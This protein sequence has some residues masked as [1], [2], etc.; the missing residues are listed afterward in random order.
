RRH[1]G[2][3]GGGGRGGLGPP[4][5][6][7]RLHPEHAG[8]DALSGPALEL[9]AAGGSPDG[10]APDLRLRR[11]A[12]GAGAT[13]R[14]RRPSRPNARRRLRAGPAP[15]PPRPPTGDR[16]ARPPPCRPLTPT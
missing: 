14:S 11:P 7:L 8:R 2:R 5:R 13:T 16:P 1:G 3:G 12:R 10:A 4:P 15:R 9:G 6:A